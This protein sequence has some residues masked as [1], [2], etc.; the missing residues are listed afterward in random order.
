MQVK[1]FGLLVR[2][3]P[4]YD[5]SQGLEMNLP[6]GAHVSELLE[7]LGLSGSRK[8]IIAISEG[9]ALKADDALSEGKQISLF[10]QIAGG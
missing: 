4:H 10:S 1:L 2:E 3:V 5:L 9:K 6:E 7:R 8:G